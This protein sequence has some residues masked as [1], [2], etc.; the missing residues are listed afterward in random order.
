MLFSTMDMCVCV[1]HFKMCC[2]I[3]FEQ[4][5]IFRVNMYLHDDAIAEI[6]GQMMKLNTW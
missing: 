3:Y 4:M 2:L 1:W 6:P 5:L